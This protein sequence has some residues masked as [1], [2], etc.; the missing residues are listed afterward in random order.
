[1]GD[2]GLGL[3]LTFVDVKMDVPELCPAGGKVK[4]PGCDVAF[5]DVDP[6]GG[7]RPPR[8]GRGG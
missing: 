7:Y 2:N 8:P 6:G 4:F 5:E 1:M 3:S